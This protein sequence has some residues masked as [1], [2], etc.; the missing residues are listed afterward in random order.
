MLQL[1]R[2]DVNRRQI[3]RYR[4]RQR[5]LLLVQTGVDH[6][7]GLGEQSADVGQARA[8]IDGPGELHQVANDLLAAFG[9]LVDDLQRLIF[10]VRWICAAQHV[11]DK[12]HDNA[13]G[14]IELVRHGSSDLAERDQAP[15][16][17]QLPF[18]LLRLFA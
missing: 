3:R 18:Q 11:F 16:G 8:G 1:L 4:F 7:Q 15:R 13:E 12:A 17:D 10:R 14:V 6:L 5:D 9:F 2:I